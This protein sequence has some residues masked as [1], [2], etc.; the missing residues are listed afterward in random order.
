MVEVVGVAMAICSLVK[1]VRGGTRQP[2]RQQGLLVVQSVLLH[3]NA[4]ASLLLQGKKG[5]TI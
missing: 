4:G 1:M 2:G 3:P 5:V